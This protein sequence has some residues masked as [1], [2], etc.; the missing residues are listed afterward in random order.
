[1]KTPTKQEAF[2]LTKHA[3]LYASYTSYAL[4]TEKF[5]AK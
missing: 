1:M 5:M 4:Y 2:W 3:Q